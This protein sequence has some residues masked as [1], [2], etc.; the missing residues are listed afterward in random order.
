MGV[1]PESERWVSEHEMRERF[2]DAHARRIA[3]GMTEDEREAVQA[4]RREASASFGKGLATCERL[5]IV[6]RDPAPLSTS[7]RLA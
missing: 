4:E 1:L 3:I 5:G 2:V 6:E 7:I